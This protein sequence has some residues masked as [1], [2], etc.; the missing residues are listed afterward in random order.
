MIYIHPV[1]RP[2]SPFNDTRRLAEGL[3]IK[4][5]RVQHVLAPNPHNE[6]ELNP[7]LTFTM[8]GPELDLLQPHITLPRKRLYGEFVDAQLRA[9]RVEKIAGQQTILGR[10]VRCEG[11]EVTLVQQQ[12]GYIIRR[13]Y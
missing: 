13:R 12:D 9:I 2:S 3:G 6:G 7:A 5:G 4:I 1:R 10:T 11:R 8:W